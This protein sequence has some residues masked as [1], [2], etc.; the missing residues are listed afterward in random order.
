MRICSTFKVF[1]V[2][3]CLFM[4]KE[5]GSSQANIQHRTLIIRYGNFRE[6]YLCS[7]SCERHE[8]PLR[9]FVREALESLS[10]HFAPH[11][12]AVSFKT[13]F[14]LFIW[15][16]MDSWI[17][18]GGRLGRASPQAAE[19]ESFW[20][21]LLLGEMGNC[22]ISGSVPFCSGNL[23]KRWIISALHPSWNVLHI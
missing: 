2:S 5:A 12:G 20:F 22:A 14:H 18:A 11:S 10:C 19:R 1:I 17:S 15:T 9:H 6:T 7:C 8:I 23:N 21:L 16:V 4:L 13:L 3:N